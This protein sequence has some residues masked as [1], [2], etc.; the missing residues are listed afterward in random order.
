MRTKKLSRKSHCGSCPNG[1]FRVSIPQNQAGN[2]CYQHWERKDN[3]YN[4]QAVEIN[5]VIAERK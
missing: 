2:A 4:K 1:S 3:I 5:P